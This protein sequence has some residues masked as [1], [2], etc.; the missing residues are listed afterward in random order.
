MIKIPKNIENLI[1]RFLMDYEIKL[2]KNEIKIYNKLKKIYNNEKEFLFDN[3]IIRV[4]I[5]YKNKDIGKLET[6]THLRISWG[7]KHRTSDL[8]VNKNILSY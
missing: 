2:N 5:G 1:Y 8:G 6:V 4:I 3:I 7:E